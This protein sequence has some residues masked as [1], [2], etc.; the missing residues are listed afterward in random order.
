MV[1][2]PNILD[3]I[4]KDHWIAAPPP[5]EKYTSPDGSDKIMLEDESGRL[6]LMGTAL[7][8]EMLVTGCI[9][10]VMGTENA[11]GDFEVIDVKLP[12]LP[13]Q[14]DRWSLE[15]P[16]QQQ[17][18]SKT[19]ASPG[20]KVALISGLELTGNDGDTLA[21]DLLTEYLLG[22]AGS[23]SQQAS[24]ANISRLIIL[25]NS[26]AEAT[27]LPAHDD[28]TGPPHGKKSNVATA[29][30]Y[31][32]DASAYNP[33]P[34]A[35]LDAFLSTLL[36]SIPIT[37]L[38]GALDPANVS[39]PQQPLH[40]A[41]F[42]NSRAY[43]DPPPPV[44]TAPPAT[45]SATSTTKKTPKPPPPA[46]P[47]HPT[48]NPTYASLAGHLLLLTS[49]Q[50]THDVSKYLPL[51]PTAPDPSTL[52]LMALTLQWRL[53]AP[54]APDTLW[55]YPFQARDPFVMAE[56]RCPHLY[57]VGN[58]QEFGTR[59]VRGTEGQVVRCVAV[60]GFRRSGGV[61]VVVDLEGLGVECL[62]FG[63]W[64]P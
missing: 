35:Q 64:D 28:T 39:M 19:K 47:L 46:H 40:P 58:A 1:L 11:N 38:P 9:I 60:P 17:Q 59:V 50:P 27:L 61:V 51:D 20:S 23:P 15:S 29:K 32:Y 34:T 31:G 53:I 43:T 13:A 30:K 63:V 22:E 2:K 42:P 36:P 48:T 52:D 16:K 18:N 33:A 4:S 3:D 5:R 41:L 7:K 21:L 10:A 45:A 54:T 12:D 49:G 37:L 55:C 8:D 57:A 26:L 62:K 25:G 14:P 44:P 6:R 24:A 56:R